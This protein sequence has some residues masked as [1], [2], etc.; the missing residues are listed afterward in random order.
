MITSFLVDVSDIQLNIPL[1]L[2]HISAGFPSPAE[3]YIE[4][5]LNLQ[6]LMVSH[7][8]ST[9]FLKVEGESMI[10]TGIFGGDILVVDKAKTPQSGDII[11]A[12][13]DGEFTV[14]RWFR[15]EAQH[16]LRAENVNYPDI[17]IDPQKH[18][19]FEIWGVVT[20]AIHQFQTASFS[21]KQK[22]S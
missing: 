8:S 10:D 20:F 6:D 21:Q 15:Q 14:K 3:D 19:D 12:I 17:V 7:P 13:L 4:D 9:Y 22:S 1:F 16:I 5:Q 11:V 2:H 18:H